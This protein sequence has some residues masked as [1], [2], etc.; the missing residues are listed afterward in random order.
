MQVHV[1]DGKERGGVLAE[2]EEL[3]SSGVAQLDSK[4]AATMILGAELCTSDED[5]VLTQEHSYQL[6]AHGRPMPNLF[7][8]GEIG[9]HN[10]NE[11]GTKSCEFSIGGGGEGG[12]KVSWRIHTRAAATP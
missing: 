12:G 4:G 1:R 10:A 8:A 5:G 7:V 9:R 3:A 6:T 2:Q 11:D